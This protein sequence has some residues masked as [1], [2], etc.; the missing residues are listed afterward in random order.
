MRKILSLLIAAL[1]SV[2][3]FAVSTYTVAGGSTALFGTSWD[4]SNT[5]NDMTLKEGT[6]YQLV[7][8]DVS[9][10]A[11]D[12]EYK[13]CFDHS[14]A[15]RDGVPNSKLTVAASGKYNVTITFD[16]N[17]DVTEGVAE[18]QEEAAVLPAVQMK[19]AWDNWTES[20]DFVPANDGKTAAAKKTFE[21]DSY[22]FKIILGGAWRGDGTEL[23][24]D[25]N[26]VAN[27]TVDGSNL[28]LAATI[29]G[30]Y[31]FT[32]TFATNTLTII[33]PEGEEQVILPTVA[34]AGTM[35]DWN[36]SANVLAVADDNK[37]ASATIALEVAEYSFKVVVDNKW[38]S[39]I[40]EG[41]DWFVITRDFTAI[42]NI[43]VEG[44]VDNN[45]QLN[46]DVAGDYTFTWTFADNSIAI[47]FP[48]KETTAV[49]NL[50]TDTKAVKFMQDGQ[51]FIRANGQVY[52]ILG[53]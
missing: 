35:N 13:V 20:I 14:W 12:I 32:W 40:H 43:T 3:M 53:K 2:S 45:I 10:P 16:T 41:E 28:K 18:L 38:M 48:K 4:P 7:K 22:E 34:I 21:V 46:A 17:G 31:T 27:L 11:G 24:K 49:D 15:G 37:S 19:G 42:S 23:T 52:S 29:A 5:A 26:T 47:T 51:L 25:N 30:E 8:S 39:N 36:T 33:F 1:V 9:L 44:G 50:T 6:V